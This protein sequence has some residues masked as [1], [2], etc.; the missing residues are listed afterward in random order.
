MS[1]LTPIQNSIESS[2]I[3]LDRKGFIPVNDKFETNVPNIYAIGDIETSHYRHV[4]LPA[5]VPLAW[6][7][8]VQQVLLPNKLLEMTPIEFKGFLGN[9]IVKFFDYTFVSVGVKPNE[10]KQFDYKMVEVTQGA[11]R[12]LL[13]RKFPLHLRVYYDTSNRQILRAAAVGKEGADKRIDVLSM[14]R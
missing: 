10:L 4:D 8:T 13:P 5:S 11:I 1:V 14:A 12:E 6:A 9:N 7:L 3:K 2:N